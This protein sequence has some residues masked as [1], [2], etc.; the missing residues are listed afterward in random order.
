MIATWSAIAIAFFASSVLS[1]RL[2]REKG[3][4]EYF[5]FFVGLI[6]GPIAVLIVLTP[7]P[8]GSDRK[9]KVANKPIRFVKGQPCPE[10]RREVGVRATK[11]PYC[12]ASLEKEWWERPVSI[13]QS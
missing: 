9:S 11:C 6:L 12:K 1:Q 7:L 2:A 10:C 5:Y 3:R 13:G 4:D 8:D